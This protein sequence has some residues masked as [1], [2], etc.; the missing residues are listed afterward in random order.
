MLDIIIVERVDAARVKEKVRKLMEQREYLPGLCRTVVDVNDR[1]NL[2]IE[3]GALC[4]C[5]R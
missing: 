3:A 2:I 1:E 5:F 4:L